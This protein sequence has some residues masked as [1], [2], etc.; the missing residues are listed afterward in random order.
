MVA[1]S[2]PVLVHIG[3]Y[4]TATSWLQQL[5]FRPEQGYEPVMDAFHLQLSLVQPEEADFDPARA[6]EEISGKVAAI[7]G[8]GRQPVLSAEALAGDPLRGGFN[9]ER[10]ALRVEQ[11]LAGPPRI[12]LVVREQRELVRSLFKT[13]VFFGADQ[14][15]GRLLE[16][17]AQPGERRFH[18]DQL[19]FQRLAACYGELFGAGS[20]CVLPYEWFRE[21]PRAF[22]DKVREHGGLAPL[23]DQQFQS[24]PVNR[25][26]NANESL[27]FI[28]AQR[29][30]NRLR[31]TAANDYTGRRGDND[32]QQVLRRISWHKR[33]ARAT[34]LDGLLERRFAARV[35]ARTRGLF[36]AGNR[37]LQA[38]CPVDLARYG[39]QLADG[40]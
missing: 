24:L 10:N 25:V 21:A 33:H 19:Q 17:P 18:L 3:Y 15:L 1:L 16:L 32:F 30:L 36:A 13:L 38:L 6:R 8:Q 40:G 2:P 7:A 35:D 37:S 28:Q 39:Y 12:L 23:S 29:W 20:V 4:K 31:D 11:V 5:Y 14:G 9:R 27:V 22:L 34:P 26:I